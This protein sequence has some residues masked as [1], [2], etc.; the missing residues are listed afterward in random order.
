MSA[1]SI[2][3]KSIDDLAKAMMDNNHASVT[4]KDMSFDEG[5]LSININVRVSYL[6]KSQRALLAVIAKV[7]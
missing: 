2:K 3:I 7:K 6:S 1:K 4:V 5:G